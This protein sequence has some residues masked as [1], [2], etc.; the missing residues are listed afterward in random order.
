MGHHSGGKW[1]VR[2][3]PENTFRGS[4]S[5][6]DVWTTL[7]VGNFP[8]GL[9]LY[10]YVKQGTKPKEWIVRTVN[11]RQYL[12]EL[13][14]EA[15]KEPEV[16]YNK[17]LSSHKRKASYQEVMEQYQLQLK[18]GSVYNVWESDK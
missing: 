4:L 7:H 1:E 18:R 9:R 3:C 5:G 2:F 15:G 14:P 6:I 17:R 10:G 16:W 13:L 12:V 8:D 11:G